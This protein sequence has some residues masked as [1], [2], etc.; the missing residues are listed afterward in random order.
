MRDMRMI[1]VAS[2]DVN[3]HF[4]VGVL[5]FVFWVEDAEGMNREKPVG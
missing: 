1:L 4:L 3:P 2:Q 5:L